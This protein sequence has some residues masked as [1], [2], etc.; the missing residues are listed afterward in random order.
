MW[1]DELIAICEIYFIIERTIDN[2]NGQL[3]G[4]NSITF[5]LFQL[6]DKQFTIWIHYW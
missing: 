2:I 4:H 6:I 1:E 5:N 3:T